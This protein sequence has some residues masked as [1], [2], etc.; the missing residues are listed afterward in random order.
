MKRIGDYVVENGGISQ[1]RIGPR[2]VYVMND[3]VDVGVI[4]NTCFEKAYFYKF[5][6]DFLGNGL[7]TADAAMWKIHRKL[8]NPAFSQQILNTFLNEVNVQAR[9]LASQLSTVA[10]T[11]PVDVHDFLVKHI[12][13]VVCRTSLGLEATDQDMIDNDYAKA[14]DEIVAILCHRGL[15]TWLHPSFIYNR[16]AMKRKEQELTTSIKNMINPIIKKRKVDLQAN[17][18]MANDDSSVT[19]KF[20]PMLD[21]LLHLSDEESVLTD[22]E[23]REHLD[24]FVAASYDTTSSALKTM[25][26]VLGSYP[27]VQERVYKEVQ[28]V[29]QNNDDLTKH[30]MSKLVYLEAVIK[31][32]MRLYDSIPWV[33]RKIH[34][35]IVLSKYTLRAGS[36]CILSLYGLHRHSSWGPDVHQFK[37][38]RWLNPAT[39]PTNPNVYAAFGIGKRNCIG[40]QYTLMVLKTSLAHIVR[41]F[42]V[43]GDIM[44]LKWKYEVV[45][46]PKTPAYITLKLRS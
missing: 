16:T 15:N 31:E 23:I 35:D 3:P 30:D 45:I 21:L 22:D 39:L 28:D 43:T 32:A 25:L 27:D 9:N 41:K 19:G 33:A 34:T 4:A 18:N 1:L 40:K 44:N 29:F 17:N 11:E 10:G 14:V 42:H 7:I 36:T 24:S 12:L 2:T 46:K 20:K 5:S 26:L 13:R 38:E 8:L 6:Q 37:P